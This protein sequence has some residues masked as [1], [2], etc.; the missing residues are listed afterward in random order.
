[1]HRDVF[2]DERDKHI[3][4]DVMKP[5]C[6][7]FI[8]LENCMLSCKMCHM[9][10]CKENYNQV[11]A[12]YYEKFIESLYEYFGSEMQIQMVGGEPLLKPGIIDLITT[13][14]KKGFFTTLTSNGYLIDRKM[15]SALIDAR[16]SS[17]ALSLDSLDSAI[18]DFL[19]GK[20]G[21][22]KQTMK[23]LKYL[24]QYRYPEQSV[25]IVTTIM[26]PNLDDLIALADWAEGHSGIACISFQVLSQPFYTKEDVSWYKNPKFSFLWPQREKEVFSVIDALIERKQKKKKIGNS[27]NQLNI[28]KKYFQNPEQFVKKGGCHLG[29]NSLSVNSSGN[30]YLCFEQ[31]PIGNIMRDR[32]EDVWES[33]IAHDVRSRIK[34][35]NRNCKLMI[36]CFSEEG[37]SIE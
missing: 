20:Q 11:P 1:M 21:V 28:F 33:P 19:R 29:Y 27:V 9:W 37:F 36:N 22:H 8:V 30:I 4:K 7:D 32:I 35:C 3:R 24:T 18:H 6:C 14:S 34:A 25:C 12:L 23:A 10:K 31:P 15:A 5:H 13:A 26:Q 16:I 2:V 17:I